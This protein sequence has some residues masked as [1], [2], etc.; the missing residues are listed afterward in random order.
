MQKQTELMKKFLGRLQFLGAQI[1]LAK[2]IR[3]LQKVLAAALW[4]Y[5]K[6][7]N[8][9]KDSAGLDRKLKF[10]SDSFGSTVWKNVFRMRSFLQCL[11]I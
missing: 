3:R 4:K 10:I 8:F 1:N 6:A 5:R 9:K 2:I 11:I 7:Y